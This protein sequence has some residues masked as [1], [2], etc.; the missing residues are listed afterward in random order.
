MKRKP[1]RW[2][3]KCARALLL[4]GMALYTATASAEV[5][6]EHPHVARGYGA[7]RVYDGSGVESVN[8]FNGNLTLRLPLGLEYPVSGTLRY[9]FLLHYNSNIWSVTQAT[10]Q[11]A[12]QSVSDAAL[13]SEALKTN[14]G[15]GWSLGFGE[16]LAPGEARNRSP[17]WVY[18]S[19]DGA[20]HP[21]HSTPHADWTESDASDSVQY[22]RDSTYLRM[23]PDASGNRVVES[24][25]GLRN[26]FTWAADVAAWR[27]TRIEDR[28]GNAVTVTY[29]AGKWTVADTQGRTHTVNLDASGNVTS[30]VLQAFGARTATYNFTYVTGAA[31]PLDC[32]TATLAP[33]QLTRVGLPDGSGFDFTYDDGAQGCFKAGR[34]RTMRV[35]TLATT[36]WDYAKVD[37]PAGSAPEKLRA[38]VGVSSR[39][40][41]D[42]GGTAVGTFTLGAVMDAQKLTVSLTTP[43]GDI[44]RR[45]FS[46]YTGADSGVLKAPDYGLPFTRTAADATGNRFLSAEYFDCDV[47][48]QNCTKL[49]T[50]YTAWEQDAR[51]APRDAACQAQNRRSP[52]SRTLYHDDLD[53][54]GAARFADVTYSAFDGLGHF[55]Q[56]TLGGSFGAGDSRSESIDY[57]ST[58][59]TYPPGYDVRGLPSGLTAA[60]SFPAAGAPWLLETYGSSTQ[61]EGGVSVK[62]E[63]CFDAATGALTRKRS[64]K[65]GT[66][67]GANDVLTVY[68]YIGGQL[69][70]ERYFGGDLQTLDTAST[71]CAMPLPASDSYNFRHEY[72]YG[73]RKASYALDVSGVAMAHRTLDRDLDLTGLV[74][75]SRDSAGLQTDFDYD[76]LGRVT[77]SQ[78]SA[79]HGGALHEYVYTSATGHPWWY[80]ASVTHYT[81]PNAGGTPLST[82][83]TYQDGFGR[84]AMVI[85]TKPDGTPRYRGTTYDALGQVTSENIEWANDQWW[86]GD[87]LRQY[88]SYDP[89][90]RARRIVEPDGTVATRSFLG[91]RTV[92]ESRQRAW[93]W[94]PGSGITQ[95]N[96][97]VTKFMDRQGRVSME[98]DTR[99]PEYQWGVPQVT[100][101]NTYAYQVLGK[102]ASISR[103]GQLVKRF[104]YDGLGN[105]LLE[106]S[107]VP[108][109]AASVEE[110][111]THSRHDARGNVGRTVNR[112]PTSHV[113]GWYQTSVDFTYDRAGRSRLVYDTANAG[114]VWKDYRYA[115]TNAAGDWRKGKLVEALR[116][117]YNVLQPRF[118]AGLGIVKDV[119]TYGGT[120]GAVSKKR[121]EIADA[122][123][124]RRIWEHSYVT[125]ALGRWTRI[126]YPRC[127]G[128]CPTTTPVPPTY[129]V[130]YGYRGLELAT[131]TVSNDKG[132]VPWVTD[133]QYHVSGLES[134]RTFGN[135]A[136]ESLTQQTPGISRVGSVSVS[137]IYKYTTSGRTL[138]TWS[139]GAFVYDASGRLAQVG[140]DPAVPQYGQTLQ[141]TSASAYS[142]PCAPMEDPFDRVPGGYEN[143]CYRADVTFL[144]DVNDEPV[145]TMNGTESHWALRDVSGRQLVDHVYDFWNWT[146]DPW[147]STTYAV[148]DDSGAQVGREKRT[149]RSYES[150]TVYLQK[151]GRVSTDASANWLEAQ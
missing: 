135:G 79:S 61:T 104:Q 130:Q 134:S 141:G 105:V 72:Q 29:A 34:V 94:A 138:T 39:T 4:G 117:T 88:Q 45:Y 140:A 48:A 36:R 8:L 58:S 127:A 17:R 145:L 18:L 124:T 62:G 97:T 56:R 31:I 129:A 37:F 68:A 73:V 110:T 123:A 74:K 30:V 19:P 27:L 150:E 95:Q 92:S 38:R 85:Q 23:Q 81:R 5:L 148:L 119:Y 1:E 2:R 41:L 35:P 12:G 64:L 100:R 7:D 20:A 82:E 14:A 6:P 128:S 50:E 67:R 133:T 80:G 28:S 149:P 44:T 69:T 136:V 15:L 33:R 60:Y 116:Y 75:S 65:Q 51:C 21:F 93:Y 54:A 142:A 109:W 99:Y 25:G 11:P 115:D 146:S 139:S 9:Q 55:R 46:V 126:D 132:T 84:V 40:L 106:A 57:N 47:N 121:T 147:L 22:T 125:D 91:I 112:R 66:S 13:Y 90:G 42:A 77:R 52:G 70:G 98:T 111:H 78:P 101:V 122:T 83:T 89:F 43:L 151:G 107:P 53:N 120:G 59:G 137:G 114:K 3:S 49:R 86:Y 102:V 113:S 108:G 26:V 63:F 24:P 131:V 144:Y 143:G 32:G 76:V 87:H 10:A 71:V 16:L 96:W 118:T 103:D